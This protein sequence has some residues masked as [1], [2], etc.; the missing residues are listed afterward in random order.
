MSQSLRKLE[1]NENDYSL[2]IR[3]VESGTGIDESEIENLFQP[4]WKSKQSRNIHNSRRG[5]GLGLSICKQ[6]CQALSGDIWLE[7]TS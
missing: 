6:I 7:S 5:N 4:F 3:V 2:E 1:G